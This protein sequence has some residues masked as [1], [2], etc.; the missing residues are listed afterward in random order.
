M[1]VV[2]KRKS[3]LGDTVWLH[4]AGEYLFESG[5]FSR[6]VWFYNLPFPKLN[7][8]FVNCITNAFDLQKSLVLFM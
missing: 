8:N 4:V 3:F 6:Y 1:D 7:K 2:V 5:Q